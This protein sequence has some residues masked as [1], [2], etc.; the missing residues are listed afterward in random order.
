MVGVGKGTKKREG[1]GRHVGVGGEEEARG[2][3]SVV[4]WR[5]G[6]AWG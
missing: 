2:V 6:E 3:V 5:L 4:T 1:E